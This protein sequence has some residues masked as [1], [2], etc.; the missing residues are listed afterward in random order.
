MTLRLSY[1]CRDL[2]HNKRVHREWSINRHSLHSSSPRYAFHV[3]PNGKETKIEWVTNQYPPSVMTVSTIVD[4]DNGVSLFTKT[5]VTDLLDVV[6]VNVLCVQKRFTED[7]SYLSEDQIFFDHWS[8]DTQ[9]RQAAFLF[10]SGDLWSICPWWGRSC[11]CTRT[12]LLRFLIG[13]FFLRHM[14]DPLKTQSTF[15]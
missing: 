4:C 9:R 5:S 6:N 15:L 7:F 10:P 13:L 1:V 14:S 3:F 12:R 2:S 8:V 11:L